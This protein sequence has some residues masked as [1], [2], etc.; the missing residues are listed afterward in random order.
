MGGDCQAP[1]WR[2]GVP[3][4][5][6]QGPLEEPPVAGV[7]NAPPAPLRLVDAVTGT[8]VVLVVTVSAPFLLP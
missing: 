5:L 8:K 7:T 3:W 1:T 4:G 6:Y 2:S